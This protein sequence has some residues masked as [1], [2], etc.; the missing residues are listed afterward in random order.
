[1]GT[2]LDS[3]RQNQQRT[4]LL[5]VVSQ[6]HNFKVF[7]LPTFLLKKDRKLKF[8][9]WNI[10]ISVRQIQEIQYNF[11]FRWFW[12]NEPGPC[13]CFSINLLGG[14]T[15]VLTIFLRYFKSLFCLPSLFFLFFLLLLFLVWY[16]SAFPALP[17]PYQHLFGPTFM[18]VHNSGGPIFQVVKQI[19][20]K[21][22]WDKKK[23]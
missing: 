7:F 12:T 20:D 17:P 10:Y 9:R 18:G 23:K 3:S 5:K 19:V 1:M 8:G 4:L 16:F 11:L 13:F 22:F 15:L 2:S 14:R 6:T 21:D